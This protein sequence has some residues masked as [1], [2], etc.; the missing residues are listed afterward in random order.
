MPTAFEKLEKILK[1]EQSQGFDDRAVIGGLSRYARVW[2]EEAH[3][4]TT[5]RAQISHI[6]KIADLLAQYELMDR[7]RREEAV[8]NLL[9]Q[10]RQPAESTEAPQR[11]PPQK[12][13]PPLTKPKATAPSTVDPPPPVTVERV[14]TGSGC[15]GEHLAGH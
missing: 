4:A 2:Q 11:P 1:L 12:P 6:N 3:G 5:E 7:G 15:L 14:S 13:S 8:A 9:A 10:L